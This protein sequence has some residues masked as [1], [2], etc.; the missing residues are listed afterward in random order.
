MS[1]NHNTSSSSFY[2]IYAAATATVTDRASHLKRLT[3]PMLFV[4]AST[5]VAESTFATATAATTAVV[6]AVA[7][8][9]AAPVV[10]I[11]FGPCVCYCCARVACT[12]TCVRCCCDGSTCAYAD[13]LVTV[14]S[15][16]KG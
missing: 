6:P 5:V 8:M 2:S 10:S 11:M 3:D 9:R 1:F 16:L 7:P 15:S 4:I 12:R 13:D 14:C